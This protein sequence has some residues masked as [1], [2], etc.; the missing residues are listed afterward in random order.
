MKRPLGVIGLAYLSALAV[1][2]HYGA[3]VVTPLLC[4]A[5]AAC[6]V[7][8]VVWKLLQ[9]DSRV[10]VKMMAV[11]LSVLAAAV[12]LTLFRVWKAEPAVNYYSDKGIYAEGYIC[13]E[14][15]RNRSFTTCL[16]QTESINGEPFRTVISYTFYG[17]SRIEPFDKVGVHMTPSA[18]DNT[19]LLSRKVFLTA[20]GNPYDIKPTG[21][22][23]FTPYMWAVSVRQS[24]RQHFSDSLEPEAASAASAVLLGDKKALSSD[25][26]DAFTKTGVSYLIVVSGMHLSI[27]SF[28]LMLILR[29]TKA[30]PIITFGVML[31][32]ILF[33]VALTGF[34][35]SVIRAAV[36]TLIILFGRI[37]FLE[38]DS[39]NSL[40]IAALVLTVTNPYA[41]GNIGLLLSF[42]ATFGILLWSEKLYVYFVGVLHLNKKPVEKRF[43]PKWQAVRAAKAVLRFLC[44]SLAAT[45][46]VI[47]VTVL[48]FESIAPLTVLI[49]CVAYP[50]TYAIL[51]LSLIFAVIGLTGIAA[52]PLVPLLNTL[53]A[54]LLGFVKWCSA[55]PFCQI[56][57][58]EA[59]YYIWLLVS[60]VLIAVGYAIHARK[61][62]IFA[63]VM[64]SVLTL[65]VGAAVTSLLPSPASLLLIRSGTG[66]TAAVR[67]GENISLLSC[68]GNAS[69]YSALEKLMQR[70]QRIDNIILP[71]ALQRNLAYVGQ[72]TAAYDVANVL[73]YAPEF[74][75]EKIPAAEVR[76]FDENTTFTLA[77]NSAVDVQIAAV[78]GKV[79]QYVTSG[80]TTVLLVPKN[81]DILYLPEEMRRPDIAVFEETAYHPEL[82]DCGRTLTLSDKGS[83]DAEA[84]KRGVVTEIKL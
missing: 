30:G 84:V 20:F 40:G 37:F 47:P 13:E 6:V 12:S 49:A 25:M 72:L 14:P 21:G 35:P 3:G 65:A 67:R 77:L 27:A 8:A 70:T 56:I 78:K 16:I 82:L 74:D 11:G 83:A 33:F 50:L 66:Y 45:L 61:T 38:S 62:Y 10:P 29:K 63:A 60:A 42:A 41:V 76:L 2:F 71:T 48:F 4:I 5:A 44:T 34:T 19:Y 79:F 55:L 80:E 36:M 24:I 75:E 31:V 23:H 28:L 32:F 22:K 43:H 17:K 1:F 39:I 68:G 69:G 57:A 54:W 26:R 59:Y 58:N 9:R 51:L 18:T 46:W 52:V 15:T 73:M 64:T 53:A 81:A 7:G